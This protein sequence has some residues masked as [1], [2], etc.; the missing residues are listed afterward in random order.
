MW[1]VFI[2]YSLGGDK[3]HRWNSHQSPTILGCGWICLTSVNGDKVST[4]IFG[5]V[6]IKVS[7]DKSREKK[8]NLNNACSNIPLRMNTAGFFERAARIK[9]ILLHHIKEQWDLK[10]PFS[11]LYCTVWEQETEH[12]SLVQ[13]P[14]LTEVIRASLSR[15]QLR[16]MKC[17]QARAWCIHQF[18]G[19]H[20]G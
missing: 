17:K 4:R 2:F 6:W 8:E 16:Q 3:R 14:Y 10:M 15:C 5:S 19:N 1:S 20:V 13:T 7:K 11:S 18:L 12:S 9:S